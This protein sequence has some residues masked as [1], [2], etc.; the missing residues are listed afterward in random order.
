MRHI[1]PISGKDSLTTAIIQTARENHDYEY[2]FNPTGLE[3]PEVF[4]WL[5]MIEKELDITIVRVGKP[6]KDIIK[7]YNYFLPSQQKRYCTRESKIE[8]MLEWIG[9]APATVYYGIR[10]DENRVGFNNSTSPNITPVY[11]LDIM[12][13]D[14]RGVY[15]ILNKYN[16]KPPTFFWEEIYQSVK[17]KLGYD[18]KPILPEYIFDML[19]SWRSRPNCDRCYNQRYYEW[20]GLLEH[21][22][23]RFW[24]AESWE[25]KGGEETYTWSSNQKSLQEIADESENHKAKRVK[26]IIKSIKKYE[27]YNL[28]DDEDRNKTFDVLAATSCGLFCGK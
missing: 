10:A 13:I 22:P 7:K 27:Q 20:V 19:F 25:H 12:G 2:F 9:K 8:P 24:E 26:A 18:P 1:I 17:A 4:T 15:L 21:H 11:P 6:L 5:D 14:L 28:F 23:D 16:L 3:L